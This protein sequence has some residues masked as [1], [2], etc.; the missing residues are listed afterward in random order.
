MIHQVWDEINLHVITTAWPPINSTNNLK[1]MLYYD[2]FVYDNKDAHDLSIV[3][4][5]C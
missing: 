2:H 4:H 5:K 3:G 1:F